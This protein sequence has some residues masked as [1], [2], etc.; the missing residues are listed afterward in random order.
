MS[1]ALFFRYKVSFGDGWRNAYFET[2]EE[3]REYADN[4]YSEDETIK[5]YELDKRGKAICE[6]EYY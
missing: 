3:A 2:L 5:I 1:D 6:V 4:N